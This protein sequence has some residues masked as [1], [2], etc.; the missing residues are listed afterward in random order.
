[1]AIDLKKLSDEELLALESG[2][3]TKLSDKVLQDIES[4]ATE[5]ERGARRVQLPTSAFSSVRPEFSGASFAPPEETMARGATA[6]MRYGVPIAAG[7][8]TG[9]VGAVPALTSGIFST[10]GESGAQFLEKAVG[11]RNKISEADIA[12]AFVGGAA[13]VF[14]FK[15]SVLADAYVK[16]AVKSFLATLTGQI[17]ASEGARAI[18]R[19]EFAGLESETTMDKA[20]E[21]VVRWGLPVAI[22]GIASKVPQFEQAAEDIAAIRAEGRSPILMDVRPDKAMLEAKNFKAGTD[23]ARSLARDMD[24]GLADV[25]T[26]A[27]GDMSPQSQAEIATALTPY[28]GKFDEAKASLARASAVAEKAQSDLKVAEFT[29]SEDLAKVKTAAEAAGIEKLLAEQNLDTVVTRILGNDAPI[30]TNQVALGA[31]QKRL[32]TLSAAAEQGVE[33]GLDALYANAGIR[34][35][36]PV[37]SKQDVLRSINARKAVGRA[38]EAEPAQQDALAAV[39]LFFGKRDTATLAEF[40]KFRDTIAKNLPEG[41]TANTVERYASAIYDSLKQSSYR[42]IGSNYPEGTLDAFRQAQ[43]RAA[44]NFTT[45]KGSAIELLKEGEFK[46]FYNAIKE[47]GPMGNM[48]SELTA[49]SNSLARLLESAK[50]SGQVGRAS[51]IAAINVARKFKE[52]VNNVI[53]NGIIDESIVGREAGLSNVQ[54]VIDPQKLIKTLGYFESKGFSLKQLGIDNKEVGK[55]IKANAKVGKEPLTVDQLN[56]FMELLPSNGGDIAANRIAY[57]K[58]VAN[59]MIEGGAK[60]KAAAFA[61]AK[62]IADEANLEQST[63]QLEYDRALSD[64]LTQ[65]F[66]EN[67]SMLL[68]NG[69]LQNSNWVDT[70][71]KKDPGTIAR[72]MQSLEGRPEIR[73]KLKDAAVAYAVKRFMPDPAKGP[74]K[75]DADQIVAPFV[76]NNRDMITIRDNLKSFIGA[77]EY[78]RMVGLVVEPLR[79]V[80]VNRLS[81]G[82]DITNYAQDLKGLLSAQGLASGRS[83]AGVIAANA[84]INAANL[85]EK[86][87]YRV[88]SMI[89]LNPEYS[90]QLAKAGYDLNRFKQLSDRNRIAVETLMKQDEEDRQADLQRQF[91]T[92]GQ[93]TR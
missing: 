51:D 62:K 88:M 42:Y 29:R 76:S 43:N 85:A 63:R 24:I 89:W 57:R 73:A 50:R 12:A 31:L 71:I 69:A 64:P 52:D 32:K 75:L 93:P 40:R 9:G 54:D 91:I 90:A 17:G 59:A 38:L 19:G 55:L 36:D 7:V 87:Y 35:N 10:L 25:V 33:S 30:K 23:L 49:Y 39:D 80:M 3:L 53:L 45:R 79:K 34:L 48:M 1:M 56:E 18:Q 14:Q 15:P 2:D 92:Q 77:K 84:T 58:A 67:G 72:F 74:V 65:F 6:A 44:A 21:A 78:D 13:P 22:S 82:Q 28:V 61:R 86:G 83:T 27:F 41:T 11:E 4:V 20:K 46:Q 26:R 8:A 70:I 81:L 37:V 16:P 68:G 66:A 47:E 5:E 60:E